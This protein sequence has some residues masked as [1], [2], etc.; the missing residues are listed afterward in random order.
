MI[1]FENDAEK[2][3]K[4]S[5]GNVIGNWR[6]GDTCNIA[7]ESL[8]V[9]LPVATWKI[10]NVPNKIS[11][12][13]QEISWQMPHGFFWLLTVKCESREIGFVSFCCFFFLN[14]K[15]MELN[16]LKIPTIK[17]KIPSIS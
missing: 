8:T 17:N 6:E 4:E 5:G 3:L 7:A 15:E 12:L 14:K 10:E 2:D 16:S 9:P 1:A 13:A 11:K